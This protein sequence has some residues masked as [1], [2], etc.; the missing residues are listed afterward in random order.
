MKA[1]RELNALVAVHVTKDYAPTDSPYKDSP[2]RWFT[3]V[4]SGAVVSDVTIPYYSS[5]IA[6]A[7]QVVENLVELGYA[8]SIEQGYLSKVWLVSLTKYQDT[9]DDSAIYRGT[10]VRGAETAPLAI[11]LAALEAVGVTLT[12]EAV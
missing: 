6:D 3:C 12:K 10:S 5:E 1:G 11:C 2:Y 7:W 4:S 8:T 9:K